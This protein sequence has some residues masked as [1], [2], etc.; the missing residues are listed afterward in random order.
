VDDKGLSLYACVFSLDGEQKISA[1][2]KGTLS[3]A[4]GLG[5]QVAQ[6]LLTQGAKEFEAQWRQKYGPW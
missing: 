5:K 2:A 3:E 4:E 1:S 6:K